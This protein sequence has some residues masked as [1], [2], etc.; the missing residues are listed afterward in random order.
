MR[1]TLILLL[2]AGC[3]GAEKSEPPAA[4]LQNE[5]SGAPAPAPPTDEQL[6]HSRGAAA[7]LSL[8]YSHIAGRDYRAAWALRERRP[9]LAFEAFAASFANYRDYRATV[10]VPSLPAEQDGTI[11]VDVPVQLYGRM[12]DGTPFGSVGRVTMKRAP[13][14]GWRVAP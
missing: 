3:G 4:N 7:A 8:Y 1:H 6:A 9:G 11:W 10:G 5:A 12:R 14:D 13:G 2:L